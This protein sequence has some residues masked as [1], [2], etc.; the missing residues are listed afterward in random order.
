VADWRARDSLS[1]ALASESCSG[2]G[3]R[4]GS[5]G[6]GAGRV[7]RSTLHWIPTWPPDWPNQKQRSPAAAVLADAS[8]WLAAV[9]ARESK[10]FAA[11]LISASLSAISFAGERT[12]PRSV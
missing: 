2:I 8:D 7:G 5:R 12:G 9:W 3:R 4:I 11:W 1:A 6:T 10:L